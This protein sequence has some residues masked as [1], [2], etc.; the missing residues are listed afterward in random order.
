M[1]LI[2]THTH[3]VIAKVISKRATLVAMSLQGKG[4]KL[5]LRFM[6]EITVILQIYLL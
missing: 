2:K 4:A 5:F 6:R 3:D 1:V